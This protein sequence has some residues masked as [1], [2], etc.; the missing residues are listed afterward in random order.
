MRDE[1]DGLDE[2]NVLNETDEIFELVDEQ[3]QVVGL[4]TR[5][6]CHS[7][8]RLLH[9]AV[10]VFVF[11]GEGAIFLQRR[12]RRKK[13]QPGRWDTSVGGH[14]APGEPP[15]EAALR[16]MEEELGIT[17][18]QPTFLHQ[19]I[20]RSPVESELVRTYRCEHEGPFDLHP[21]E[22]EEGRFCTVEEIARMAEE[23]Q[24][25]PNLVHELG[26]LGLFPDPQR[27]TG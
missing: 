10:H 4:A 15:E 19:Y 21:G 12:S 23:D 13:I 2:V 16:E 3:G 26:L 20:W 14:V 18:V 9:Q 8:P 5:R 1:T 7:D 22:I 25:T 17:A 11:N 27:S 6:E 24:L